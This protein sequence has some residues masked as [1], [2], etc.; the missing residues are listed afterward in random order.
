VKVS[1]T[2]AKHDDVDWSRVKRATFVPFIEER[3]VVVIP[4]DGLPSDEIRDGED[5]VLDAALRI[6]LQEAGFRRQGT[7]VFALGEDGAHVAIWIDGARY[8]GALPHKRDSVWWTGP[9][10]EVDDPLVQLADEA[11]RALTEQEY[12]DD[13]RRILDPSYLHASTPHGGSGFGGTEQEWYDARSMIVDAIERDGTFLDMGCANGHLMAS[14]VEW[15]GA[16]GVRVEPY[17]VDIS[18]ALVARARDRLPHWADRFWVGDALRWHAPFPFD[19]VHGLLDAVPIPQ[20]GDLVRNLLDAVAPGGRLVLSQYG[21]AV[22]AREVVTALGFAIDGETSQPTRDGAPRG[23]P[24]V[25]L[26]KSE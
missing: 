26:R 13:A 1:W 7:H 3:G 22:S 4:E 2:P 24:S 20:R 18:P 14:V 9:P 16:K 21:N 12:H 25:W 15:C 5:V 17:G 23:H 6:P 8:D 11:R 10:S 19:T